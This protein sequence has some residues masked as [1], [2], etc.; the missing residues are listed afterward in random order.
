MGELA[1]TLVYLSGPS[2]VDGIIPTRLMAQ[3]QRAVETVT[4]LYE[5]RQIAA[6][7][8]AIY[9]ATTVVAN[10]HSRK[11]EMAPRVVEDR[12]GRYS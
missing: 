9:G 1:P 12:E 11:P 5:G 2:A 8:A 4:M 3:E 7:N 10:M 6:S